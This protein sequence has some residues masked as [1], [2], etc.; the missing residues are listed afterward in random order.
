MVG[1]G[2]WVGVPSDYFDFVS[3]QLELWL[4]YGCGCGCFL[5]C[6]NIPTQTAILTIKKLNCVF[7]LKKIFFSD[8]NALDICYSSFNS[9]FLF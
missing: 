3:T 1:G 2:G 6:D 7:T 9:G 4:F 8:Y 5:G